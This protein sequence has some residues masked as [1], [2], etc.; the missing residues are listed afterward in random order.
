[1]GHTIS[2]RVSLHEKRLVQALAAKRKRC[3]GHLI[4]DTML[5]EVR[6][7]MGEQVLDQDPEESMKRVRL[8]R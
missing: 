7:S 5:R 6:E 1:M 4:R 2:G 3:V 8:E